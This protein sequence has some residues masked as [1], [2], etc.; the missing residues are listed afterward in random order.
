MFLMKLRVRNFRSIED[1]ELD[2]A[3]ITVV[4]GPNGAGKS[5]L[6]YSLRTLKSVI[7]DPNR[8]PDG[9][10]NYTFINLGDFEGVVFDHDLRRA[11]ELSITVQEDTLDLTYQVVIGQKEGSLNLSAVLDGK[12]LGEFRLSVTFP[13]SVSKREQEIIDFAGNSFTVHWDG[14]TARVQAQSDDQDVQEA[15]NQL[16]AQFNVPTETLRS[17]GVVPLRR[18]FSKPYYSPVSVSSFLANEDEVATLLANDRYLQ[19]R[20]S[21]YLEH[22]LGRDFRVNVKLGTSTFSLDTIDKETGLGTELVNE[23]F[24]VNQVVHIL[25]KCLHK[26]VRWVCV[27]EPEVHL[28]PSAVRELVRTFVRIMRN[29]GKRFLISTHSETLVVALLALV[30]RD[31][32]TPSDLAFYWAKKDKKSTQFER[33]AANEHGQL[34]GGLSSFM[35]GELEDTIALLGIDQ[36]E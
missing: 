8:S 36:A 3:P 31:E 32:I 19:Q 21:H 22:T 28:H 5:S 15:A 11:L 13:Y 9:F 6:L 7:F 29:E 35:L 20:V 10:F 27:E 33:Q 12:P 23:G 1:E 26:D 14:I 30:A 17:I 18:G 16:T 24:G 25:A 2:L 34:E 4:Y